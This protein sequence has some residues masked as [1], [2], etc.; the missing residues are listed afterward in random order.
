M[1]S[2][3]AVPLRRFFLRTVLWLP[4]C[5]FAWFYLAHL[6]IWPLAPLSELVLN[7]VLPGVIEA[8]Q[9]NQ[10][11][12]DFLTLLTVT[13]PDGRA[14]MIVLSVNPL[15]YG[16]NLPLL[17]ALMSAAGEARFFWIRLFLSYAVLLPFQL[18]GVC[19][20]FVKTA[21]FQTGPEVAAQMGITGF[22]LEAVALGYQFGF[23]MLPVISAT[24]VWILMNRR[25][26]NSLLVREVIPSDDGNV[27]AS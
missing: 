21:L 16:Y 4:V 6:L 14:G 2:D 17:A 19:F 9:A 25:F 13:T 10:R 24:A 7:L 23:L 12:L 5:F 8:V 15:I 22:W 27:G 18:W 26:I 20:D 1:P 3:S 11:E